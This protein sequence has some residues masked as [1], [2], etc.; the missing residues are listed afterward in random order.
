MDSR[1]LSTQSGYLIWILIALVVVLVAVVAYLLI[2]RP[3]CD[4]DCEYNGGSD[5]IKDAEDG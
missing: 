3:Y 2:E 4:G 5:G 1:K